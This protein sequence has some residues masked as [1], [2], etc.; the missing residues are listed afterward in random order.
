MSDRILT[1]D[2]G[3]SDLKLAEFRALKSGGIELTNF[4][5]GSLGID[6]QSEADRPAYIV[7]ALRELMQEKAI[8]PGRVQVSISG[9]SVF[10]RFVKLPPVES[11]KLH[12][13]VLY[14]AQQNVPFPMDEV[15]WDYQLLGASGELDV[16]LAAVKTEFVEDITDCVESGGLYT[17][18]V[19]V[20]PMALY[21]AVRYS[22]DDLPGCTLVVDIGARSTDLIFIEAGYFF[23]RSIPVAGNTITQQIMRE[24]NM[25]FAEA[26]EM[27]HAHAFVAFG[28]AYEAPSSEVADKV[29]KSV[30]LVMTRMHAEIN[31]SINF[32]RSQQGGSRPDL[33][34]LAGG[35]SIIPHSETFLKEKLKVDVDY[36][37]PLRNVV[38]A[39]H[40][41]EDD[42]ASYAHVLGSNIGLALRGVLSCP[43]EVNLL[44]EKVK[45]QKAF[46]KKLPLFF[47]A[48]AGLIFSLLVWSAFYYRMAGFTTDRLARINEQVGRLAAVESQ[49]VQVE[50]KE[51]DLRGRLDQV[52]GLLDRRATWAHLM[53]AI[54]SS[55]PNGMW[56]IAVK[57][58]YGQEETDRRGTPGPLLLTRLELS[59]VGYMD[60]VAD[61]QPIRDFR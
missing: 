39:S 44:P 55:L 52:L 48:A 15:V 2:I 47:M 23:N 3:A 51:A 33:I 27:K 18:L 7:T 50:R 49:L 12:Q 43:I 56:L 29:S 40:I 28:G 60:K 24:F 16:M 61:A 38:V 4:A 10:S 35:S 30:R 21:N 45:K 37:N 26:E 13:I 58:G 59:G 42:V 5:V 11:D 25:E 57:P 53:A 6:L 32:Y 22:Y 31:R 17:D 36:L 54:Q 41:S 19:D 9:Q 1:L 14:E 46:K 34:L 20:A 8:K